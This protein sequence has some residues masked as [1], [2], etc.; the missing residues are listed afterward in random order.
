MKPISY[1]E[2]KA[3]LEMNGVDT[4][5]KDHKV[6]KMYKKYLKELNETNNRTRREQRTK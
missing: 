2:F 1:L 6:Q 3:T 5:E 4:F